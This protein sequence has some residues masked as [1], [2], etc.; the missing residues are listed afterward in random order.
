MWTAVVVATRLIVKVGLK[1]KLD[2]GGFRRDLKL[3]LD[4]GV[5]LIPSSYDMD[6]SIHS[7]EHLLT[8]S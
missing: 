8:A 5:H 4:S 7:E 1:L 2:N 3:K 6:A